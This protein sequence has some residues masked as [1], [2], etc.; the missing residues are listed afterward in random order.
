M[1][2][3]VYRTKFENI[4]LMG[5]GV[6][7]C[8]DKAA[9]ATTDELWVDLPSGLSISRLP[10]LD[11]AGWEG[12]G[13]ARGID[14]IQR[15]AR[16][17]GLEL[18]DADEV[19][20]LYHAEGVLWIEPTI[21]PVTKAN[22]H[23]MAS[24]EWCERHDRTAWGKAEAAGWSGQAIVNMCKEQVGDDL[25][26][27]LVMEFGDIIGWDA[28][29]GPGVHYVQPR[30]KFHRGYAQIDYPTG[31]RLRRRRAARP[32]APVTTPTPLVLSQGDTGAAV[33]ALRVALNAFG[34]SP[35]LPPTGDTFGPRTRAAVRQAQQQLGLEETGVADEQLLAA[36]AMR[37]GV[38]SAPPAPPQKRI[39]PAVRTKVGA[40]VLA[41]AMAAAHLAVT[42]TAPSS[43]RLGIAW[44]QVWGETGAGVSSWNHNLG[45][46]KC[47]AGWPECMRLAD[48]HKD[49]RTNTS[50]IYRSYPSFEAAAE[51]Y[52]RLMVR[53]YGAALEAF[54][55][56]DTDT[57]AVQLRRLGYYEAPL[58][59]YQRG[60][61]AG[62]AEFKRLGLG[63]FSE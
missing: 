61:R 33:A 12:R 6:V 19:D 37:V 51:D 24:P 30:S 60:L 58:V 23:L 31:C 2:A 52:W 63:N 56:G 49:W 15:W 3:N 55:R 34:V 29:A 53:R 25:D 13:L 18:A 4:Y 16:E 48:E 9:V 50:S 7:S 8:A 20:E 38:P 44:A 1:S 46:I 43:P 35:Q 41:E 22:V 32:S 42:G 27:P 40:R 45:N 26:T 17:R 54:D 62:L 28:D 36:L 39:V 21:I 14:T 11:S 10:P 5:G 47:T 57:A 59:N